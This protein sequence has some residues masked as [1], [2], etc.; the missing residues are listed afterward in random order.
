ML[1]NWS[2]YQLQN[3]IEYKAERVG[4]KVK[5]IDPYHTSQT[6]SECG[7]YEEGQRVKKVKELNKIHLFVRD[8]G[9]R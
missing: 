4:I 1:R 6:C 2:Y 9:I 3:F 5:Y 7:N 8:V